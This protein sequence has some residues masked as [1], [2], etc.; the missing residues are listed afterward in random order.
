MFLEEAMRISFGR[1]LIAVGALTAA[2]IP[3]AAGTANAAPAGR[4]DTPPV[5]VAHHGTANNHDPKVV[6]IHHPVLHHATTLMTRIPHANIRTLASNEHHSRTVATLR[7]KGSQVE[8][9]CYVTGQ[10]VSG[11][12]VWYRTTSP[13]T[14]YIAG[15]Q[16]T[17][18]HE[19]AA[20]VTACAMNMIKK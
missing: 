16:L 5:V 13:Q 11:D 19:P 18:R 4:N 17:I 10:R 8:V 6:V 14:G 7:G 2:L 15:A 12:P 20:H 9:Q 1:A 3:V